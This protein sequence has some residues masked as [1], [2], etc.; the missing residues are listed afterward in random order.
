MKKDI[1]KSEW[2]E[3]KGILRSKWGHLTDHDF[4]AVHGNHEQIFGLLQKRYGMMR[5]DAEK[6]LQELTHHHH[7]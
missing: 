4:Q 1:F 6:Q 2:R 7:V 3:V 5:E